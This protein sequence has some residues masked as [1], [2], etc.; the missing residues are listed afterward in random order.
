MNAQIR[1]RRTLDAIKRLIVRESLNQ[2]LIVIFEDLHWVD[3]ETQTFLTLF[4]DSVATA[5]I[6]LLT[7]YR[8]EYQHEWGNKLFFSQVRLDPLRPADAEEMLTAL[9]GETG[10]LRNTPL[11]DLRRLILEK[12]QGNPFFMEEIVQERG[13]KDFCPSGHP[14]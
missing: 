12:T 4:S 6:L 11:Q 8:P 3:A 9:L 14:P 7:N 5:K 1:K 10:T 2:P 13:N